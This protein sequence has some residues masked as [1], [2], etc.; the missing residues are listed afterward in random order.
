[1]GKGKPRHSETVVT[2]TLRSGRKLT[3]SMSVYRGLVLRNP[4]WKE[5]STVER[6]R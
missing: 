5:Q 6:E 1:M 4:L 2:V 3:M